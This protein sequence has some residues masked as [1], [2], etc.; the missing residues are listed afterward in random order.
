MISMPD[1]VQP[2]YLT[3]SSGPLF[4]IYYSPSKSVACTRNILVAPSFA[5]EMNRCRSMV[6]QQARQLCSIGVG[7][8]VIDPYGTADSAGDFEE[9]TW[10]SWHNDLLTGL[11]WLRRQPGGCDTLLG[12]RLGAVMA[13]NIVAAHGGLTRLL[14]WQPVITGKTFFNQFLRIRVAADM[15]DPN[16]IKK[17]EQLLQILA[18]GRNVE[19]SGYEISPALAD[20]VS[21]VAFPEPERL[22]GKTIAWFEIVAAEDHPVSRNNSQAFDHLKVSSDLVTLEKIVGPPFWQVHE[23][24]D[25]PLLLEATQR[26]LA[27]WS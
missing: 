21:R 16:G 22:T 7:T 10:D 23:R 27:Q 8:L 2:F 20:A 3:G 14:L 26:T 12:I 9:L 19:V 4:A 1:S 5:E 6:S 13:A 18:S 17:T 24:A 15:N 11:E 25:A